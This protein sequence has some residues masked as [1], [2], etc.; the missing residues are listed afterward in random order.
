MVFEVENVD[1]IICRWW[2]IT[3]K[4]KS[5]K[6]VASYSDFLKSLTA[7][8]T[9]IAQQQSCFCE[10]IKLNINTGDITAIFF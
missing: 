9:F 5:V 4:R 10:E 6:T 3:D 8:Y 2:M 7:Y 1:G